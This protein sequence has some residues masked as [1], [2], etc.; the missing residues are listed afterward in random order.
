MISIFQDFNVSIKI[1]AREHTLGSALLWFVSHAQID[2]SRRVDN[3]G[4]IATSACRIHLVLLCL[5][6]CGDV[7]YILWCCVLHLVVL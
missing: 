4:V 2:S 6:S 1:R 3:R 5:T 7:S